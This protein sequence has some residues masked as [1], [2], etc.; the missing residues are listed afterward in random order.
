MSVDNSNFTKL[1]SQN[2]QITRKLKTPHLK[3]FL[4]FNLASTIQYQQL[5][6]H[7]VW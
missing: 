3:S 6:K 1:F 7:M 5:Y 2:S 4:H